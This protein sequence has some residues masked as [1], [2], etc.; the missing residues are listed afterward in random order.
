M[1]N[2]NVTGFDVGIW[3]LENHVIYFMGHNSPEIFKKNVTQ[4]YTLATHQTKGGTPL[5]THLGPLIFG[6]VDTKCLSQ[7]QF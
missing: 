1:F 7:F 5:S 4:L 3:V 6:R 2:T